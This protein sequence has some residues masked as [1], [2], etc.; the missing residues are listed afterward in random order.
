MRIDNKNLSGLF[1]VSWCYDRAINM[2]HAG[3]RVA[4]IEEER[5]LFVAENIS[6][7]INDEAIA[8]FSDLSEE[9]VIDIAP[10][11]LVRKRFERKAGD[12]TFYITD[13]CNS[14][15]IM[16]PVPENI[17]KNGLKVITERLSEL[18]FYIP[19][20]LKHVTITGG[21]PFLAKNSMFESLEILKNKCSNTDFLLLS[22]GRAFA[23][24]GYAERLA[25]V[26]PAKFCIGIPVHGP[27]ARIHDEIS[28]AE[29]SFR[30][31]I[32][33]M[34]RLIDNGIDVEIRIVVNKINAPF[35]SDIAKLIADQF[36]ETVGVRIMAMEMLG[37]AAKNIEKVWLP[38]EKFF[39]SVEDAISILVNNSIDV[40]IYNMP[41]CLIKSNYWYICK[42][43]ISDYKIRYFDKCSNCK[44]K[45]VCGGVF[46]GTYR[47]LEDSI[48]P[49]C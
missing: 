43:S 20:D 12:N 6:T 14:N 48:V 34:R 47:F 18:A 9:D 11:G 40:A 33:G 29:G 23:I 41:L 32:T 7:L 22:N 44:V 49:V 27:D 1:K 24:S 17:R 26:A 25:E 37:N 35:I 42:Q 16:C 31:T 21:E 15:C 8:F 2:Y 46:A 30:Q 10:D 38:Y 45:D 5:I 39:D 3:F 19:S 28:Q 4:L 13:R 36:P